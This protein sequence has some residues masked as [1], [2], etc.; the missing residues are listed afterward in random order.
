MALPTGVAISLDTPD[1]ELSENVPNMESPI[2]TYRVQPGTQVSLRS[3]C[4]AILKMYGKDPNDGDTVK[5]F[6]ADAKI[7][8]T[9]HKPGQEYAQ[10]LTELKPYNMYGRL[11]VEDQSDI[12]KVEPL[13]ISFRDQLMRSLPMDPATGIQSDKL[14]FGQDTIIRVMVIS[15]YKYVIE[16][17]DVQNQVLHFFDYQ[18]H[19]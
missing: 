17:A 3:T 8:I 12:R 2:L 14:S 1:I 19:R 5:E 11:S 16:G 15:P 9:V 10:P 4:R 6:P 18:L 13:K 7:F